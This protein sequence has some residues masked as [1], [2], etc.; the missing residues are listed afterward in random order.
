MGDTMNGCLFRTLTLNLLLVTSLVAAAPL[1]AAD[2]IIHNNYG[3]D[4]LERGEVD[5]A[6]EQLEKAYSLFATDQRLKHNLAAAYSTRGQQLL[7]RKAYDDAAGE[8]EKAA[9]LYP[10]EPRFALL[11]GVSLVLGKRY[12]AGRYELERSRSLGGDTAEALYF[13]GR[14][15]YENG[16]TEQA[17]PLW[18]K[19]AT[20]ATAD[21]FLAKV[22]DRMRREQAVEERM[23][24]GHSSRF[25]VSY[26]T[27]TTRTGIA[28]DILDVLE[29]HY[30]SVGA[31]LAYYPEARVP[32]ILYTKQEYREVTHSPTWSGG[33]YDGKIR[34]PVGGLAEITPR[35]RA[36]LR[37]EYTHAVI[38][39]MTK[40]NCPTW[41]NEGI[42]EFQGRQEYNPPLTELPRAVREG[43][44]LPLRSLEQGLSTLSDREV[45]LAYEQSYA[46]INFMVTSYGWHRV[47][48]ILLALGSGATVDAAINSGLADYGLNYDG[49]VK[50]WREQL[51]NAL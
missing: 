19:A 29:H 50:E 42:A 5:K 37:H 2:P 34:L 51:R 44:L 40:D 12:D 11:R 14:I 7:D 43:R 22:L 38:R 27:G 28:L 30:N 32:L 4:L 45:A 23:V 20:L 26:D 6:I 3:V 33:L 13:L 18:E 9:G 46:L 21:P 49:M 10:N 47:Q 24:R 25:V 31:D 39:D 48:A 8:F 41:L 1:F 17:L 35:L 16:E 15:H 36:T